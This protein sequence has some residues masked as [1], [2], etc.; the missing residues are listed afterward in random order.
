[1]S[2][3]SSKTT[4]SVGSALSLAAEVTKALSPVIRGLSQEQVDRLR[5]NP[6]QLQEAFR[7]LIDGSGPQICLQNHDAQFFLDKVVDEFGDK[8]ADINIDL[9]R[10]VF[11]VV[12]KEV[13]NQFALKIEANLIESVR[14]DECLLSGKPVWSVEFEELVDLL[15]PKGSLVSTESV[16]YFGDD[17]EQKIT[18][19][20]V[21]R[22]G[23]LKFG[24]EADNL[25]VGLQIG[26][27]YFESPLS[28]RD[29]RLFEVKST[30]AA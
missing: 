27:I 25:F 16:G 28:Y 12:A 15:S 13:G 24:H 20:F 8:H 18:E 11:N 9:S 14:Y 10:F 19:E 3:T 17:L 6:L 2:K 1:M 5:R 21:A 4:V 26:N 7:Q 23:V 29:A 30:V 22:H